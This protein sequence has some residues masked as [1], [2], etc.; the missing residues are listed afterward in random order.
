MPVTDDQVAALRALLTD[1]M[2]RYRTLFAALDRAEAGKGYM[3][4]VAAAFGEAT[5]RRFGEGGSRTDIITFVGGVRTRSARVADA[6]DPEVAE[7]MLNA[8]LGNGSTQGIGREEKA[9]AQA[10]LLAGL[11]ADEHLDDAGLD[12]FLADARK[13]AN[14]ILGG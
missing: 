10:L 5:E 7:R 1:D 9:S 14:Q 4:L 13:L 3:A 12:A 8:A 2:D 11:I 6:L